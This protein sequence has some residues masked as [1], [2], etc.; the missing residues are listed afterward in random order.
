MIRILCFLV[1]FTS[2]CS[3]EISSLPGGFKFIYEGPSDSVIIHESDESI[4]I[5]CSISDFKFDSKY[6]LIK[7]KKEKECFWVS[8]YMHLQKIGGYY[9]WVIEVGSK[10]VIGPLSKED[11]INFKKGLNTKLILN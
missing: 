1:L 6:I 10:K 9:Y 2:G 8:P 3:D 11:F 5:S 4:V 7:Q